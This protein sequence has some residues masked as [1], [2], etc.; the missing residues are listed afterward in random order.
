MYHFYQFVRLFDNE[1]DNKYQTVDEWGK[2]LASAF[3]DNLTLCD[4]IAMSY[5][6]D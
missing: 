4:T 2:Q 5:L 3:T 1:D 6:A